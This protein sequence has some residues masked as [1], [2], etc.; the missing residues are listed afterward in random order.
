MKCA[1]KFKV[2]WPLRCRSRLYRKSEP[3]VTNI[4]LRPVLS[5][6]AIK[7]S[8]YKYQKG[9]QEFDPN[10]MFKINHH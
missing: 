5:H 7:L 8:L 10:L 1:T 9:L 2:R 4:T 6:C 3:G